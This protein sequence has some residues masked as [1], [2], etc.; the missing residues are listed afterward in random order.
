ME[1]A[2]IGVKITI[3]SLICGM[4]H[5][6]YWFFSWRIKQYLSGIKGLVLCLILCLSS[7]G[8]LPDT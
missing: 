6:A 7:M 2:A 8:L 5:T 1:T 3:Q 4:K